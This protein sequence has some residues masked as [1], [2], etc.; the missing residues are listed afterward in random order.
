[1]GPVRPRGRN[2]PIEHTI[3]YDYKIVFFKALYLR[4]LL[5]LPPSGFVRLSVG[6]A[7]RGGA[8]GRCQRSCEMRQN[9]GAHWGRT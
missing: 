1:M 9:E 7:S 4:P 3:V 8:S 6:G 5:V 2:E